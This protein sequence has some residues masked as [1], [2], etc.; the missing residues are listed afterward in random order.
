MSSITSNTSFVINGVPRAL[1]GGFVLNGVQILESATSFLYQFDGTATTGADGT[2]YLVNKGSGDDVILKTGAN[3]KTGIDTSLVFTRGYGSGSFIHRKFIDAETPTDNVRYIGRV[4]SHSH[5]TN[6]RIGVTTNDQWVVYYATKDAEDLKVEH[7]ITV[8]RN[9]RTD[10]AITVIY[11]TDS[12]SDHNVYTFI[13]GV[14]VDSRATLTGFQWA[15]GHDYMLIGYWANG[16]RRPESTLDAVIG[17]SYMI[18]SLPD[19]ITQAEAEAIALFDYQNPEKALFVD[20]DKVHSEIPYLTNTR[21]DASTVVWYPLMGFS[22]STVYKLGHNSAE[23][24]E[25]SGSTGTEW[26]PICSNKDYQ[27]ALTSLSVYGQVLGQADTTHLNISAQSFEELPTS[28]Y[29]IAKFDF[30]QIGP[31]TSLVFDTINLPVVIDWSATEYYFSPT[32]DNYTGLGTKE[33]PFKDLSMIFNALE[34]YTGDTATN[35]LTFYLMEGTHERIYLDPPSTVF[36][37]KNSTI[38]YEP[39]AGGNIIFGGISILTTHHNLTIDGGPS[40]GTGIIYSGTEGAIFTLDGHN[41]FGDS[42]NV[43][44]RGGRFTADPTADITLWNETHLFYQNNYTAISTT[45]TDGFVVEDTFIEGCG[46]GINMYRSNN[47]IISNNQIS[48]Y[49]GDAIRI[50]NSSPGSTMTNITVSGNIISDAICIDRWH[51]DAIQTFNSL[52]DSVIENNIILTELRSSYGRANGTYYL[53]EDS[54]HDNTE[55]YDGRLVNDPIYSSL[56][57]S[58][59]ANGYAL[60]S[61]GQFIVIQSE[62]SGQGIF[63]SDG[64]HDNVIIR[65][66][67]SF[68]ENNTHSLT[69][70]NPRNCTIVNNTLGRLNLEDKLNDAVNSINNVI[71]NNLI[72]GI[73]STAGVNVEQCTF[74]NNQTLVDMTTAVVDSDPTDGTYDFSLVSNITG[75]ATYAPVTDINGVTRANPPSVGAYE[76]ISP[77]YVYL[78][79]GTVVE[80]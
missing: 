74:S 47:S 52:V 69:V 9:G 36:D 17:N 30:G 14:L 61:E 68:A 46:N 73:L 63:L 71:S 24:L 58:Y 59:D 48:L 34:N 15:S 40:D 45:Y 2:R 11:S 51:S 31:D 8:P 44:I 12:I 66:N 41:Y 72:G 13:N 21:T 35:P 27:R 10:A 23:E 56:I 76:Y 62:K 22:G 77:S 65:N 16:V 67:V 5:V 25:V 39:T 29:N 53:H 7:T 57:A 79:D 28:I 70:S 75:D 64:S 80:E 33:S 49:T 4:S 50:M 54:V 1:S 37:F 20:G 43:T 19:P 60:D 42:T 38:T 55:V 78:F 32:G 18:T 26:Q 6:F 3:Y